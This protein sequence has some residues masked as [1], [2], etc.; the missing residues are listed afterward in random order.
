MNI[1]NLLKLVVHKDAS[2][3][4]LSADAPPSMRVNGRIFKIGKESLDKDDI[5]QMV[6]DVID[7]EY[8]NDFE[9]K[10]ELNVAIEE[11]N[12]GRFRVN[13]FKQRGGMAAVIRIIKTEIPHYSKLGLPRHLTKLVM[14]KRGLI[15]FVGGTGS[16]KSSSMASLLDYRNTHNAGHIITIEDPIEFIHEHKKG[17]VNQ[18]EVGVD[19]DSYE[20]ALKNT[21]RQSP[22]VI[23]IGEIRTKE[24]MEQALGAA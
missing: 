23:M 5:L 13:L 20:D 15:L 21:L 18:R 2:D 22:D 6:T 1:Q 12:I 19:T 4:Y 7:E 8:L 24:T 3:L 16:G 10:P 14:K 9:K 11:P 17:M